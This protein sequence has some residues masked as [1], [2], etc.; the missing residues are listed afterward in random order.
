MWSSAAETYLLLG[1]TEDDTDEDGA[2]IAG[3]PVR[4]A[5]WLAG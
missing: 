3:D 2:C 4:L 1:F 5:C